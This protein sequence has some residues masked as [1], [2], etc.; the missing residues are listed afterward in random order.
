MQ[1]PQRA[2]DILDRAN[3]TGSQVLGRIKQLRS[4]NGLDGPTDIELMG[5]QAICQLRERLFVNRLLAHER[6]A[7]PPRES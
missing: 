1:C 3:N 2:D 4:Q 6:M 7:N 5:L